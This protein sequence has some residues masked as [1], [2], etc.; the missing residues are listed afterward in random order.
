MIWLLVAAVVLLLLVFV[1]ALVVR[2]PPVP[3]DPALYQMTVDLHA[4][5]RRE[6]LAQ[7]KHEVKRDA[8]EA[9]RDLRKELGSL[10]RQRKS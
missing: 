5:R 6:E 2:R 7:F 3:P 1:G 8:A 9:R 10:R 4:I